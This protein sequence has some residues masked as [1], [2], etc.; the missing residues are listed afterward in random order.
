[1]RGLRL[2]VEN[3]RNACWIFRFQRG[4]LD[5]VMGLGPLWKVGLEEARELARAAW[6]QLDGGTDP[7]AA[8][9]AERAKKVEALIFRAAAEEFHE[10][11]K[12]KWSNATHR[13]QFLSSLNAF[14]F[15]ILGD[16]PVATIDVPA[17]LRCLEQKVPAQ[18]GLP[19]GRFWDVRPVTAGR[20]RG[21]IEQVLGWCTVRGHRTGTNPAAWKGHLDQ[22]LPTRGKT[23]L[24][25]GKVEKVV[26]NFPALPY[27]EVPSFMVALRRRESVAA[28]AL[29]FLVLTGAR[30][31][32]VLGARWDEIDLES[33]TWTVPP[34]RMKARKQHRTPLSPAAV[35]LLRGCYPEEGNPFVFIGPRSGGLSPAAL[36]ATLHRMGVAG[37]AHGFRSSFRTWA[38][39]RTSYPTH[40]VELCLAHE[41]G[42]KVEQAYARTDLLEKR[43]AVME[44]WAK[45]C[46]TPPADTDKVVSLRGANR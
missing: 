15:P 13:R 34:E 22:V 25:D 26:R 30:S 7:I 18:R 29:E 20:V 14:A 39:E 43:R 40:V 24:R 9:R 10:Q 8:R 46:S 35:E 44:A 32:E 23:T 1:M 31:G 41:V 5:R 36:S 28:R 12:G 6:K 38:D 27:D 45:F 33:G 37:T 11:H 19:A 3:K 17:V 16:M 2:D 42:T 21:R 4:G